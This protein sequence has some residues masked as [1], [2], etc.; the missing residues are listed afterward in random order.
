MTAFHIF[1]FLSN[2]VKN[3]ISY[4]FEKEPV[5]WDEIKDKLIEIFSIRESIKQ[6]EL[7]WQNRISEGFFGFESNI[8]YKDREWFYEAV[9]VI[10]KDLQIYDKKE[11]FQT[12]DWKYF[13]DALTLHKFYV[14]NELLPKYGIIT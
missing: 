2:Q 8:K 10:D 5:K 7:I 4:I 6:R 3:Y 1:L 13:H 12:S 11:N 9:E 14:K